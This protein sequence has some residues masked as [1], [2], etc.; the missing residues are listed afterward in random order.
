MLTFVD[1]ARLP[2]G[3]VFSRIGMGIPLIFFGTSLGWFNAKSGQWMDHLENNQAYSLGSGVWFASRLLSDLMIV[4]AW[5]ALIIL[6][7]AYLF[8][9]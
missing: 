4:L 6:M 9:H 8:G 2:R 5:R 3:A 1:L 7:L